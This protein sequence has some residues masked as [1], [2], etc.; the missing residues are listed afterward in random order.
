MASVVFGGGVTNMIGSHAGNTF[1]RN[2]GGSYVKKKTH[3][4]NPRSSNQMRTRTQVG[5]L[6]KH[7]TYTLS[8]ADRAA[9]RAFAA[10]TPVVNR[11]GN[12]T[13][14][15]A[16]QMFAKLNAV[17]LN[18]TGIVVNTPPA[19][20]AVGTPTAITI[21]ATSG[22]GGHLH[23]TVTTAGS[24]GSDNIAL[25]VSPPMNP[26]RAFISSQLRRFAGLFTRDVMDN[27]TVDYTDL[28]GFLP[29]VAGQRI[30]VR[31]CV[32]NS[33]NGVSSAFL[34]NSALWT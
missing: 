1:A 14:L 21:D 3:G 24:G 27:V 19:S 6:A 13:F 29:P 17:L 22:L 12:T 23:I 30:F 10:T 11:L 34:Q 33:T 28:F 15:S 2:K 5:R 7:Y 4:T 18:S 26:G 8:D 9:W 31:T 16:Q 25:W 32:V 20:Y